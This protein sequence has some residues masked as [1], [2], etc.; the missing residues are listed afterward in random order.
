MDQS[1]P[2][3]FLADDLTVP[4]EN[5]LNWGPDQ[6]QEPKY[7]TCPLP[8]SGRL[9]PTLEYPAYANLERGQYFTF[10]WRQHRRPPGSDLNSF[11]RNSVPLSL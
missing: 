5:G 6:S 9:R 7:S 3:D 11:Q 4:E 10:T 1:I 2:L 8:V